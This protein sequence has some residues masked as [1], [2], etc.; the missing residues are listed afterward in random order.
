M[1]A[2]RYLVYTR[3][4]INVNFWFS[5]GLRLRGPGRTPLPVTPPPGSDINGAMPRGVTIGFISMGSEF[6]LSLCCI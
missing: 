6:E 3:V 2:Y 1:N 4:Y 5:P